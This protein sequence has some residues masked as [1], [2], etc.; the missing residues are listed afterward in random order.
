VAS[1]VKGAVGEVLALCAKVRQ[2]CGGDA[3][4]ICWH[5]QKLDWDF[6]ATPP[7]VC[8]EGNGA[9]SQLQNG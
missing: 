1:A 4:P 3:P 2:G 6:I 7:H 8:L 5:I 9:Q